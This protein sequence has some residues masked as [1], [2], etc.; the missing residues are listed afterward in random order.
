MKTTSYRYIYIEPDGRLYNHAGE[1]IIVIN[2]KLLKILLHKHCIACQN[3]HES[4][5][6]EPCKSCK[7]GFN[8][9]SLHEDFKDKW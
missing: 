8:M 9:F 7:K 2:A 4:Y 3:I 1:E 5:D 6:C